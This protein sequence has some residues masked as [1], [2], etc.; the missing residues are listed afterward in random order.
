M[1]SIAVAGP[2]PAVP[3]P[4]QV[5]AAALLRLSEQ[6]AAAVADGL[7]DDALQLL[8]VARYATEAVARGADPM[9]AR[10]AVQQA[11]VSLRRAVWAMRP[12][13][14]EGLGV[15][16]EELAAFAL[17]TG[18][19]PLQLCV[20]ETAGEVHAAL[21]MTVFR[22]VQAVYGCSRAAAGGP[23]CVRA[24]AGEGWLAVGV[25]APVP[26]PEHWHAR[27][28]A[29]GGRLRCRPGDAQLELPLPDPIPRQPMR[30]VPLT[31]KDLS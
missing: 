31:V 13:G 1:P 12:R 15:A 19:P 11:L 3:V 9:L 30:S 20:D 27:A 5:D 8:V 23:V 6:A 2:A 24:V 26:D 7:H 25:D 4:S 21:G 22:F 18:G 17:E 10:D 29:L 14:A 28:R 16:L